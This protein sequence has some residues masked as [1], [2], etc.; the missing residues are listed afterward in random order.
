[1]S[2]QLSLGVA[3]GVSMLIS[4][5]SC[6]SSSLVLDSYKDIVDRNGRFEINET[7]E[8]T[9]QWEVARLMA[10]LIGK[11][12]DDLTDEEK[13]KVNRDMVEQGLLICSLRDKLYCMEDP[14][15]RLAGI[16]RNCTEIESEPLG[17]KFKDQNR[18]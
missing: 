11:T 3:V 13:T 9:N 8:P 15:I 1:M 6:V 17:I 7:C 18:E 14:S 4:F 16:C 5:L 12:V 10:G 2:P